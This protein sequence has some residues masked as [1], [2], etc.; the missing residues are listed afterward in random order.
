MTLN[1][2]KLTW[3]GEFSSFGVGR[4]IG[5]IESTAVLSRVLEDAA[6]RGF[7]LVYGQC[8]HSDNVSYQFCLENGGAMS[9]LDARTQFLW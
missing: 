6:E 3:Y 9:M 5:S 7:Q 4:L 2:Q 1:V 8:A